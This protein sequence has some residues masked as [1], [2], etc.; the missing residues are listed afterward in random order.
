MKRNHLN[1]GP[2]KSLTSAQVHSLFMQDS[3]RDLTVSRWEQ[4]SQEFHDGSSPYVW[5]S[6]PELPF[7]LLSSDWKRKIPQSRKI[8]F[9]L[10]GHQKFELR[11]SRSVCWGKDNS[12]EGE[13][14]WG[15]GSLC[16]RQSYHASLFIHDQHVLNFSWKSRKVHSLFFFYPPTEQGVHF[17]VVILKGRPL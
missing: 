17:V 8:V 3:I 13:R 12:R 1:S 10:L 4:D 2:M 16:L 7:T 9:L 14:S 11:G 15:A 6:F 5:I